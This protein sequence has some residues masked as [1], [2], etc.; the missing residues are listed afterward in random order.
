MFF[1]IIERVLMTFITNNSTQIRNFRS[2]CDRFHAVKRNNY[3]KSLKYK[4]SQ[5]KRV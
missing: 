1:I 4:K 2:F 3:G 5:L